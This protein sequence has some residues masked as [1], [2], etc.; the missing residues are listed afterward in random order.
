MGQEILFL[1]QLIKAVRNAVDV[2]LIVGGGIT[3]FEGME[4]AW[5]AGADL[6]VL[7][8]VLEKSLNFNALNP[9]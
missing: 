7:G 5:N 2:P 1:Q 3:D 8:T 9:S 4:V 6:V